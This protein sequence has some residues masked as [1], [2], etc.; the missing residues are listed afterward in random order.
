MK[1]TLVIPAYN[2]E[3]SIFRTVSEAKKF[4]DVIVIDDCSKD[5]TR[6]N[7]EM[8]GAIVF[9][10][11]QNLGY[12]QTINY[13][14]IKALELNYTHVITFDADGQ[15]PASAISEF[16][17]KF[18]EG[19]DLVLGI[20][21]KNQRFGETLFSIYTN[22]YYGIT[23]P[24]SGLKG[25]SLGLFREVGVFDTYHSIG[26]ELMFK[27]LDRKAR[28]VQIPYVMNERAFGQPRFASLM[29]ANYK[30]VRALWIS[31]T[32]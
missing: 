24:L 25:Y 12:D 15:H 19:F 7:A 8:A 18:N 9:T 21:Q 11:S 17:Q 4:C 30:I 1:I 22:F 27:Y 5:K 31:M 6:E 13:G 28:Y 23:D 14:F 2:E 29:R 32:R 16:I 3:E 26:T 20:R 10:N